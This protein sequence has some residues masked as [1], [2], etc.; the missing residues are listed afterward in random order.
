MADRGG[1]VGMMGRATGHTTWLS[2]ELLF[3]AGVIVSGRWAEAATPI[4]DA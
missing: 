3:K 1:G 4:R 2:C